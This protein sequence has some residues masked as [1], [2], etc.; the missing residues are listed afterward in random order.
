LSGRVRSGLGAVRDAVRGAGLR[1]WQL[2]GGVSGAYFVACQGLTVSAIGVTAFTIAV[3]AGQLTSG[4]VVD[5][6]GIGP[7]GVK[8][9]TG[10]RLAA[11]VLAVVAVTIAAIGRDSSG[12][13]PG[14]AAYLLIILPAVAGLGMAWQQAVNGRVAA[15]GG[16]LPATTVNFAVGTVALLVIEVFQLIRLGRP[17]HFPTEP[18]LYAGGAIGVLFIAVAALVVRW[19]G[20][21]LLGL[22]SVSG[23]LIAS[24]VIDVLAPSGSRLTAP[25]IAGCALTLVS[26]AIAVIER[27]SR[28]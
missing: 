13:Q 1:W 9:V 27:P 18:W 14:G 28:R 12:T 4:L 2:L 5:R 15:V 21:L 6:Q 7:A 20:V 26:A 17:A 23:Q 10:V 3:V 16:P 25:V 24:V 22:T 8:P 19:I 11:A